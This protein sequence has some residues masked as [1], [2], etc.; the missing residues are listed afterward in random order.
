MFLNVSSPDFGPPT[1]Q[2]FTD[3]QV[4][5]GPVRH[6]DVYNLVLHEMG[7]WMELR[8][9]PN[10]HQNDAVMWFDNRAKPDLAEDDKQGATMLHGPFTGWEDLDASGRTDALAYSANVSGYSAGLPPQLGPTDPATD[11]AGIPVQSGSKYARLAGTATA[12]NSFAYFKLFTQEDDAN[13][14]F[15]RRN[16]VTITR[17]MFLHWCQYNYQQDAMSVDFEMTDDFGNITTLRDSG[18]RDTNG[19]RVHPAARSGA[20]LANQ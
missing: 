16:Y 11:Q 3:G 13:A 4:I 19:V 8:D 6:A 15:A 10:G 14:D 1:I 17:G 20:Y 5:P 12:P 9:F 18:L 2:W 7:H